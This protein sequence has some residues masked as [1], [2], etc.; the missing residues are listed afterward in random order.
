MFF[1]GNSSKHFTKEKFDYK[2]S[3]QNSKKEKIK[4]II[5]SK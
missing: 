4:Q 1:L 2:S 5:S 3:I